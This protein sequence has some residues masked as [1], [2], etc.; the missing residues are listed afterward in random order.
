MTSSR[1]FAKI[2]TALPGPKSRAIVA[3]EQPLPGARHPADLPARR[4]RAR[5]RP[6]RRRRRRRRQSL[7]RL[8]RR[9]RRGV[10]RSRPPG[11]GQGA[12]RSGA[13]DHLGQLR[14]RGARL[15]ARAH[16]GADLA[17]RRGQARAHHA[18]LGRL[19]GGRIG[20]AP[21][22]RAHQE[23]RSHRLLGRLSRQDHRRARAHGLGLQARPRPA[24]AGKL[25]DAVGRSRNARAHHQAVDDGAAGR[26][27]RRA[28]PGHRRQH[29]AAA[30]LPR[31]ACARSPT[32]MARSS[33]PT[34]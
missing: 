24:A 12:A 27:H 4:P 10:D 3:R 11:A 25:S 17:D 28:D 30:R 31:R 32:S 33:S 6:G 23:A 19:R 5:R 26:D 9:H 8:Q 13:Q 16:R 15:A 18:L 20:A 21:G 22:A 2:T 14:L 7:P 34:R 29:P 1:S